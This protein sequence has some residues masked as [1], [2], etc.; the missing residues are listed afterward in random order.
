VIPVL[1]KKQGPCCSVYEYRR[2]G[3]HR[4][5]REEGRKR[6]L[7]GEAE[8]KRKTKKK[9]KKKE[10]KRKPREGGNA[11]ISFHIYYNSR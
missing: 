7:S 5:L 4:R 11:K 10:K 3:V 6:I 8:G 1:A 9:R 2:L